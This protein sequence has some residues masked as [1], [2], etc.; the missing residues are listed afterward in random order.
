MNV[1]G[2]YQVS[3]IALYISCIFYYHTYVLDV[4]YCNGICMFSVTVNREIFVYENI[5]VLNIRV[6]KFSRV[7]HENISTRKFVKLKLLCTYRRLSDY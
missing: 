3:N 4:Y 6:N 5:H 2:S 1:N 7:P